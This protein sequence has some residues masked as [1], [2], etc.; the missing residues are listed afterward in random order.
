MAREISDKGK[1]SF[2]FGHVSISDVHADLGVRVVV[3]SCMPKK[4]REE[5]VTK[6]GE[7][8][9]KLGQAVWKLRFF[10]SS[11]AISRVAGSLT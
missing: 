1:Y 6:R 10:A 11:N 2:V 7:S 9:G 5:E 3:G 8:D 4:Q